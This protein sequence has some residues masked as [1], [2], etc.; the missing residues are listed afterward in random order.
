[1]E[2]KKSGDYEAYAYCQKGKAAPLTLN[3]PHSRIYLQLSKGARAGRK[4]KEVGR[5]NE[6]CSLKQR[7]KMRTAIPLA[8]PPCPTVPVSHD[9]NAV[10]CMPV[11]GSFIFNSLFFLIPWQ[12]PVCLGPLTSPRRQDRQ[13]QGSAP[14][15]RW[16]YGRGWSFPGQLLRAREKVR[17]RTDPRVVR[18]PAHQ[19]DV[20][21]ARWTDTKSSKTEGRV[22]GSRPILT[23]RR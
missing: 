3:S 6:F 17:A 10:P 15:M 19:S 7:M 4:Q 18:Q 16:A 20:K 13:P 11:S 12:W 9:T 8:F 23:V 1:M 22:V 14:R 5:R 21:A 2:E